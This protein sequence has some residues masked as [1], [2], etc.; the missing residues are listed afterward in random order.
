MSGWAQGIQ[1][2]SGTVQTEASAPLPGATV[3]IKG[4][5]A[6]NSTNEEG[7]FQLKAD[8]SKGPVVLLT[9]PKDPLKDPGLSVR[10][11]ADT[12]PDRAPGAAAQ[13]RWLA[14]HGLPWTA[15]H[16]RE[17]ALPLLGMAAGV[18]PRQQAWAGWAGRAPTLARRATAPSPH[19]RRPPGTAYG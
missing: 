19:A 16:L 9:N 10:L 6:G 4:T 11:P 3:I 12:R 13:V 8:F 2:I 15:T 1:L 17:V 7:Q 18:T 14:A 5:Y